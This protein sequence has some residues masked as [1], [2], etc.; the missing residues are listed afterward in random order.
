MKTVRLARFDEKLELTIKVGKKALSRWEAL[1]ESEVARARFSVAKAWKALGDPFGARLNAMSREASI[2][3]RTGGELADDE[4]ELVRLWRAGDC[5]AIRRLCEARVKLPRL[6]V[7]DSVIDETLCVHWFPKRG[8]AFGLC[9]FSAAVLVRVLHAWGFP[10]KARRKG[11]KV[12]NAATWERD[13]MNDRLR[14]L[15][16]YRPVPIVGDD[17]P[18]RVVVQGKI[19]KIY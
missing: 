9:W 10:Q 12:E 18:G 17:H 7:M 1:T 3:A 14:G 8:D 19:V 13:A 5:K 11:T 6:D 15:G 4:M 16:L 2:A